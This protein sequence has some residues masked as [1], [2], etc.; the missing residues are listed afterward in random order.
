MVR[1]SLVEHPLF[2]LFN[3]SL[4]DNFKNFAINEY[5]NRAKRVSVGVDSPNIADAT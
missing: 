5:L 4:S 3:S 1:A 2:A